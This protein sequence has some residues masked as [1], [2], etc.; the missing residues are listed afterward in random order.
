MLKKFPGG[1]SEPFKTISDKNNFFRHQK[2][3]W[4][5]L[6]QKFNFFFEMVPKDL[7]KNKIPSKLEAA[8]LYAKCGLDG[9]MDGWV[10]PLRLLRLLEHLAVLKTELING[11]SNMPKLFF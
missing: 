10:I 9:W 7:D 5:A 6:E 8:P 4:G 11:T 2:T 3:K 1:R